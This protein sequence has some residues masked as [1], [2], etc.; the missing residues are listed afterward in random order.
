[1]QGSLF[2]NPVVLEMLKARINAGLQ[3]NLHFYR[4][5]S[6][7]EVD[8]LLEAGNM[9]SLF[10]IKS[11]QTINQESFIQLNKVAAIFGE[12]VAKKVV[13]Y[14]GHEQQ[15]RSNAVVVSYLYAGAAGSNEGTLP[16]LGRTRSS[17]PAWQWAWCLVR[18]E[19]ASGKEN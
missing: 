7:V 14:A 16:K 11:S 13:L 15:K 12:R 17:Y 3:T 8:V 18:T 1:L 4:D 2:E 19:V 5:S 6:G 10:E 9:I